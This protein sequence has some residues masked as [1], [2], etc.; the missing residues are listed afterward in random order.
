MPFPYND[1]CAL[2]ATLYSGG[3][4]DVVAHNLLQ[5]SYGVLTYMIERIF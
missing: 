3:Y 5:E 1:S 2:S 4:R